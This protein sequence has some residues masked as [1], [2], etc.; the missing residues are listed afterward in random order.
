MPSCA[1]SEAKD[2]LQ[3]FNSVKSTVRLR[4]SESIVL[5]IKYVP[6][7]LA[8][9]Y[10]IVTLSCKDIGETIYT[11][12][13]TA[14][15][16]RPLFPFSSLINARTLCSNDTK[17]LYL[18]TNA[19]ELVKEELIIPSV[20]PS[21]EAALLELT[22]WRM[23]E[24]EYN[25]RKATGML[26]YA[27]LTMAIGQLELTNVPAT[28]NDKTTVVTTTEYNVE[29]DSTAEFSL[30]SSLQVSTDAKSSAVLPLEFRSEVPGQYECHI[31]LH[32]KYDVRVYIIEATV[33]E[34][35]RYATLEFNTRATEPITQQIPIV[36]MFIVH[37][38]IILYH[39]VLQVNPSSVDWNLRVALNGTWFTGPKSFIAKAIATTNYPLTFSPIKPGGWE[40]LN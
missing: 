3:L 29:Y 34:K 32:S 24:A 18:K 11:I 22:K 9:R 20:N 6:I 25:R 15:L 37:T 31:T 4:S 7:I 5:D 38:R 8:K 14:T 13:V 16:P 23:S 33:L 40:V 1:Y 12:Q 17:T 30:P 36:R 19:E 10:C 2:N 27:A 39:Y 21:M 28:Y 26:S 35:G